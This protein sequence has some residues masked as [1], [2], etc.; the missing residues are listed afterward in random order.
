MLRLIVSFVVL[1]I[2]KLRF[3]KNQ[4]LSEIIIR[5]YGRT[6]L[7]IFRK[8]ETKIF[9]WKK[10]EADREF[11]V[12]CKAYKVIPKFMKFKL[13]KKSYYN[14]PMYN[15]WVTKLLLEEIA[16]KERLIKQHR[17]AFENA[18]KSL[19]SQVSI[20]DFVYLKSWV[21]SQASKSINKVKQV[22]RNKLEKLQIPSRFKTPNSDQTILNFSSRV[23]T[24]REKCLLSL[25]L[26]FKIPVFSIN[27]Y[28]YFLGFERLYTSLTKHILDYT[29]LQPF[30]QQIKTLA[31]KCYYHFKPHKIFSPYFNKEDFKIIKNLAKDP[32]IIVSKP[33]KG[34]GVVLMDK[35]DYCAKMETILQDR[36]KFLPKSDDPIRLSQLLEDKLNRSLKDLH[37]KGVLSERVYESLFTSS[38]SP[39]VLYGL[40]KVHKEGAPLRPILSA[41][42]MHNYNLAKYLVDPLS[43][44]AN[45]QYTVKDS[46]EFVNEITK[47]NDTNRFFMCS[48]DVESL[49]TNVPLQETIDIC[50]NS[51]YYND[52]ILIKGLNKVQFNNLLNLALKDTYLM[53]NDKLYQQIDGVSMGSPTGPVLANA[54]LCFHEQLWL[55]NCP[56]EFKPILYKRYVDDTF[57]LF[58]NQSHCIKFLDYLNSQHPNIKFTKQEE[59]NN[60]ISFLDV[61]VKRYNNKFFT[62]LFRKN[63]FT[64]LGSNFFSFCPP[65]F[66]INAIKT[67]IYRAYHICSTYESFHQEVNFLIDYFCNNSFPSKLISFHIKKF[68]N[69]IFVQHDK[70]PTVPK[71]KLFITLPYLGYLSDKLKSELMPLFSKFCP[72]LN[73]ILIFKNDCTL[74]SFFKVKEKLPLLLNSMVVYKY[75]CASCNASYIGSTTRRLFVRIA[76]HKGISSRTGQITQTQSN[77]AIR[78]HSLEKDHP[79]LTSGFSII[80]RAYFKYDLLLA[81]SLH[82]HN[83]KPS[84][85]NYL[86]AV[87]L[88]IAR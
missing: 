24:P 4:S 55:D 28:K 62:S 3:P 63:T 13:Y 52:D 34:R 53:F 80:D 11:L 2:L 85:N 72:Q 44:L 49:F 77:S 59:V 42:N 39:G 76:E 58:E 31:Y 8:C 41:C 26:E 81:E 12:L 88:N 57:I 25:G 14:T 66:K 35:T 48:F 78:D 79:L 38:S 45:N 65:I 87:K 9:K 61:L 21:W 30:R 6:N 36:H 75:S 5:R 1:F 74:K 10:A 84:L 43:L 83:D 37:I 71:Q 17:V 15:S 82:I 18:L 19:Q 67:L 29:Q 54:F 73:I 40:P 86:S 50:V 33:D 69:N 16:S 32:T 51:L 47:I 64:G 23:L 60:E 46:F 27:F 7:Q 56:L 22:H 68:L 20:V 70:I